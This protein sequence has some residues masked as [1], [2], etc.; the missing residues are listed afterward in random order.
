MYAKISFSIDW[1]SDETID[2]VEYGYDPSIKWDDLT[3]FQQNAIKEEFES[4]K[5]VV[6]SGEHLC[7]DLHRESYDDGALMVL[8]EM[9]LIQI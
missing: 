9:G 2:L 4:Q 5:S 7:P 3:D 1:G 6:A 8:E